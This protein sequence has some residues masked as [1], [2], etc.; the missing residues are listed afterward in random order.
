[1][2][3]CP[4]CQLERPIKAKGL[5]NAC[6]VQL[7]RRGTLT[8]ERQPRGMCTVPGCDKKAHGRGLCHMHLKRQRVSGSFDDPRADN[9]NLMTNQKLYVQW[10]S[11]QRKDAYP[12]VPEWKNSFPAFM[13]AVG[14]RPS[15]K[16][17]LYRV[18][19]NLPLGP[20]NFEW[21]TPLVQRSNDETLEEYSARHK[22]A[23]RGAT[24]SA[25]WDN[26]L[27]GKYGADFGVK[28]LHAMAEAQGYKCAICERPETEIRNGLVKHLAVDHD[29][30]TGKVRALLC[31]ACNTGLGKFKDDPDVLKKAIAYL[32]K[33]G[34]LLAA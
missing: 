15:F 3:I 5:C 2:T 33:H 21:R 9:I 8:R 14:E 6:Y 18:D 13:E 19:K 23:R 25:L 24:G 7:K 17:R 16:H 12:I 30:A 27:R 1:M 26:D 11:Y 32:A 29:H 31:A 20:N 4:G 10:T 34:K 22:Y 28:E